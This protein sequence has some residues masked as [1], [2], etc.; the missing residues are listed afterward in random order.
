MGSLRWPLE[1]DLFDMNLLIQS[2][3]CKAQVQD[4]DGI[5]T[6]VIEKKKNWTWISS[7]LAAYLWILHH[8]HG[9]HSINPEMWARGGVSAPPG[10]QVIKQPEINWLHGAYMAERGFNPGAAAS[11]SIVVRVRCKTGGTQ[12]Q[13]SKKCVPVS[14]IYI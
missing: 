3:V 5:L 4:P 10:F 6:L 12:I 11:I 2:M 9:M 1:I 14:L 13:V 7:F 8:V